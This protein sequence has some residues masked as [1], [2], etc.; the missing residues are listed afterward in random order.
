MLV[1]CQKLHICTY[2]LQNFLVTDPLWRPLPP[3]APK[4][5]VVELLL[6]ITITTKNLTL[7]HQLYCFDDVHPVKI[8]S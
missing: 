8:V 2:A 1:L 7:P 6:P 5:E 4:V 3:L